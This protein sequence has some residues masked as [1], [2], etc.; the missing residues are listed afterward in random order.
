M[1]AWLVFSFM[2]GAATLTSPA[3][4][5]W[6][7]GHMQ[8][9]A[10]AY[11]QLTPAAR[12]KVDALIR[13]SPEY[14]NWVAGAPAENA[15]QYAFIRA[16]TWADDIKGPAL[17]HTSSGDSPTGPQAERNIG[18]YDNLTHSYW[19]F[20]DIGFST[21]GTPVEDADPVNAL[22]EIKLLTQ[23]LSPSS[24]LPDEVRS[25]DL[26]W[27]IHLVGDAHQPLH[28]TTRFSHDEK[29]GDEGGNL[30]K[31]V[32]ATGQTIAL[33]A[34]WHGLLGSYS[35]PQGA[36]ADAMTDKDM[37]LP[38]ADPA[39]ANESN[40]EDWFRES[41]KL[42]EDVAYA[43]PLHDCTQTCELDRQY[44]TN[45]RQ[46]ARAQAALA[47]ARLANLLNLTLGD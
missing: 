18:Y 37:R 46:T 27:L 31:V 35:T 20:K 47:A 16:S 19:H 43:G 32:P 14:S 41:E 9:A 10:V 12:A 44:E 39:L 8:I 33:H 25:Y 24:G 1:R 45:A 28:A 42:A 26:V 36:I 23:G 34:Y 11:G 22:S 15:A 30:V 29:H 2:C 6:D 21:D 3:H 7:E 17:G 13:L 38:P 40:P 5:W 4:A